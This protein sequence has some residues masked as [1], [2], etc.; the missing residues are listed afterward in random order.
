MASGNITGLT[1][2]PVEAGK[3]PSSLRQTWWLVRVNLFLARRR[4]MS[5]VL[6]ALLIF[7]YLLIAGF[8]TL[9]YFSVKASPTTCP[10]QATGCPPPHQLAAL[11]Q[12]QLIAI[13]NAVTFPHAFS[14]TG[15]YTQFMGVLIICIMVGALVGG[16]YGFGTHR[17]SLPRG[18]SRL[19]VLGGQVLASAIMALLITVGLFLLGA[20][21]GLTLG[22]AL[23][24][25]VQGLTLEGVRELT[26]YCLAV[27][28]YLFGYAM[29]AVLFATLGRSA[30]AGIAGAIGLL[31]LEFVVVNIVFPI[32]AQILSGDTAEK[33]AHIPDWLPG[34]NF[35]AL[36][37]HAGEAPVAFSRGGQAGLDL[38]HA[39]LMT[40]LYI[41][42][43]L[44]GSYALFRS[45]D[46]TD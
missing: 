21:M 15:A 16:E 32:L 1:A 29:F 11:R 4:V 6:G 34:P 39:A 27:A 40:A 41:A 18:L 3:A 12:Q 46:V 24:G 35:G 26:V 19:Q 45:R 14:V 10:P 31:F 42:V 23:G 37:T 22:P 30:A 2:A 20:L 5:K 43:C 36:V 44:V 8:V 7:F 25:N 13:S 28:L 17:L 33:V 9:A 38:T